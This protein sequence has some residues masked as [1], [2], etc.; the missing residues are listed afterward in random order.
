MERKVHYLGQYVVLNF[1]KIHLNISIH[2]SAL[3]A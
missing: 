1:F 3:K 2:K